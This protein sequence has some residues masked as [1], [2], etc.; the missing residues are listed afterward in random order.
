MK[1]ISLIL[2]ITGFLGAICYGQQID[3]MIYITPN[4]Q[5]TFKYG[6]C[7]NLKNSLRKYF[8]DNYKM[9][10]ILLDNG[11]NGSIIVECVIERDST[12]S[13]V[14]L[15]RGIDDPLD[16]SVLETIRLMPKWCPGI[17]NGKT[18]RT[19][20]SIPVSIRWL[21]GNVEWWK[22]ITGYN[23]KIPVKSVVNVSLTG[24]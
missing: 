21:Y 15:L 1:K 14:K 2:L 4:I 24:N 23:S 18:V 5:P 20:F 16:K 12:I 9:P 22:G 7:S 3:T 8:M 6:T 19:M 13:N 10:E 11:Y 17:N